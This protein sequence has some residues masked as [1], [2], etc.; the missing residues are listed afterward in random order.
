MIAYLD[1]SRNSENT[2]LPPECPW[3]S[4]QCV[5]GMPLP[6]N[7]I[8]VTDEEYQII[9]ASFE[10]AILKEKDRIAME[11][12][13]QIKDALIGEIA[14]ENKERLRTGIWSYA[15]LVG[16]LNSEESKKVMNEIN[17]LSF[18]LAQGSIMAITNPIITMDIKLTWVNRLKENL[19]L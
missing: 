19:F 3:T 14:S 10:P 15:D 16:F 4:W 6:E 13:A 1:Q 9:Y 18:E 17:G 11:K 2:N 8:V 7:A 5:D 12:R